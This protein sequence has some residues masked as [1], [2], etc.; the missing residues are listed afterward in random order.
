MIV[1]QAFLA[2]MEENE[3]GLPKSSPGRVARQRRFVEQYERAK[4]ALQR[5]A[6]DQ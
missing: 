3:R 2:A 4:A 1:E 6:E 5:S